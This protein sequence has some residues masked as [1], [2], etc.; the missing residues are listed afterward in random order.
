MVV[1]NAYTMIEIARNA[2][3]V[4][5]YGL[6]CNDVDYSE[7][8]TPMAAVLWWFY[9]SKFLEF[10]DTFFFVLRKKTEHVSFLHLY[11]HTSMPL[12]WWIAIKFTPGGECYMSSMINSFI[13]VVMYSYYT[14]TALGISPWWKKYL[15]IM[16]MT[17]FVFLMGQ[18]TLGL[19]FP[20]GTFP[21][22]MALALFFYMLS[23]LALFLNFYFR[24]YRDRQVK[25][26]T[27]V[28]KQS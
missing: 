24:E 7:R 6:L 25:F 5:G 3:L 11:H 1:L 4:L 26:A 17:Q 28:K 15:T 19:A 8:G 13:H 14:L 9:F 27:S 22:W 10:F 20:C 18:A 12:L 2:F 16:Q 23:M 21:R